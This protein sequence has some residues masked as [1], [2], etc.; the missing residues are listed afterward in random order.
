MKT[1]A[2]IVSAVCLLPSLALAE[3]PGHRELSAAPFTDVQFQDAFW[4]PRLVTNREISL[5]HNFQWCEQTGRISN[6]AKAGKLTPGKFEG[7][8]FNDSDVFKVLEGASYSLAAHPDAALESTVDRVLAKI[9]AA[10]QP[11][12][13]LNTYFTLV[14]PDKRWTKLKTHHE[15]YCAGHLIEGAVAHFR[16]T[17]KRT[18]L[19]VAIR[20]ADCIDDTFGPTKRPGLCGHEEIELALVK[21]Y[22]VTGQEKYL[23]LAKFFIDLRGDKAARGGKTWGAYCQDHE[24]V[25]QQS[26]IAGHAVRAMYLYSG[27][28][29][30]AAYTGDEK[31]IAA[32]DRLWRDMVARK[33]YI[34][35]GIGARGQGEAFGNAYELPNDAAYCETC[36]A[37]GVAFWAHRLNLMHGDAQYADVLERAVYN[38]ILAGVGMDGRHFFYVNPLASNGKHHR[39]PFFS[40]ACCPSNVVRFLPSLPGYVYALGDEGVYVNLYV[41]G[42]AKIARMDNAVA[43]IQETDYPWDG[44]VKL[45]VEPGKPEEFTVALRVPGWCRGAK[46]AV[47]GAPVTSVETK[48]GYARLRRLWN[49]GDVIQLDLPMPVERIEANP[50]VQ[51]DLGRVAIQRGPIVYCLEAVDNGGSLKDVV[52]ARDPKFTIE[53]RRDLL[54]GV[55][56]IT[57][58]GRDGRKV[59]AAPYYAWDHRAAGEMAVWLLQDG[60]SPKPDVNDPAWRGRLYRPFDAEPAG[61]R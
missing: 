31:L 22:Q 49:A 9:A 46:V 41:A 38:G 7:I 24:P 61:A 35:G 37:I 29:D 23:K 18:F 5:P 8:Y 56:V 57:G 26:E 27:V 20:Y 54:G 6:F 11:D 21:L 10:Q 25:A 58:L 15:L 28:A 51:A 43:L 33:M 14:E 17:G 52:L 4:T 50:K 60:K 53:P 2:W 47:N 1:R 45:T 39:Q 42:K 36:A 48:K 55:T 12:G 32:M 13:Y 59:T 16:A 30:V 3:T 34:T 40:C 19:D 44:R